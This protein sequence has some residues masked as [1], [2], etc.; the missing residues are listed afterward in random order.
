[1]LNTEDGLEGGELPLGTVFV[2]SLGEAPR[3]LLGKATVMFQH[4]KVK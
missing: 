3:L 4:Q 2:L 1:M